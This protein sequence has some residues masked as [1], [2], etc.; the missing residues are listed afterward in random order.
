MPKSPAQHGSLF[1]SITLVFLVCLVGTRTAADSQSV[2]R[3]ASA[4]A[5]ASAPDT[6]A[7]KTPLYLEVRASLRGALRGPFVPDMTLAPRSQIVVQARTSSAARV[8]ML[9]CDAHSTLSIFPDA[10][11]IDFRA[12]QWVSLPAA[13]MPIQI[14]SGP[15]NETVYVIATRE[16]LALSDAKLA[17][18][19]AE[20][21]QQP[22]AA[23]CDAQLSALLAGSG[24]ARERGL[25]PTAANPPP[26][27]LPYALRGVDVSTSSVARAFAE[28]DGVV[29]LRFAY[30]IAP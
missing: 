15:G 25:Q 18:W 11:G 23:P 20:S 16:R 5:A 6:S 2:Q 24:A 9:H 22:Q 10:G 17:S 8:Y 26:R 19:L 14:G 21:M 27:K 4:A 1:A 30:T 3:R 28:N 29:V 13:D 7:R 12:D